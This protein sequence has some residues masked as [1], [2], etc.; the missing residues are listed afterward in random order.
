MGPKLVKIK[1]SHCECDCFLAGAQSRA[2]LNFGRLITHLIGLLSK[3]STLRM[4]KGPSFYR[5][6]IISNENNR[7]QYYC[8]QWSADGLL[9]NSSFQYGRQNSRRAD[10]PGPIYPFTISMHYTFAALGRTAWRHLVDRKWTTISW[11]CNQPDTS[12]VTNTIKAGVILPW[13]A[14]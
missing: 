11:R 12:S 6:L 7:C 13:L 10:W 14:P 2:V 5:S 1:F 3:S 4:P 9:G 8:L